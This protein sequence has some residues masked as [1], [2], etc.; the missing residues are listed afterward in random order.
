MISGAL[1]T[2]SLSILILNSQCKEGARYAIF[3]LYE[4]I[5]KFLLRAWYCFP[6]SIWVFC[7][8][9]FWTAVLIKWS[10]CGW[11]RCFKAEEGIH[12]FFQQAISQKAYEISYSND[13]ET[14]AKVGSIRYRRIAFKS[15]TNICIWKSNTHCGF[16]YFCRAHRTLRTGPNFSHRWG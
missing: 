5:I 6:F 9:I 4:K 11:S 2:L 13:Y 14:L 8:G 3:V 7:A 1:I 15:R 10:L 12:G 16:T